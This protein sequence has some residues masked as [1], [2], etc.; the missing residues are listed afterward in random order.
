VLLDK[1][2]WATSHTGLLDEPEKDPRL[3]AF[4][5]LGMTSDSGRTSSGLELRPKWSERIA[6]VPSAQARTALVSNVRHCGNPATAQA[7]K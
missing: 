2:R 1:C 5:H 4:A 7:K 3:G 6:H